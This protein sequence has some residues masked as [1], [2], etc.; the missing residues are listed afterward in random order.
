MRKTLPKHSV[1]QKTSPE[2]FRKVSLSPVYIVR[3]KSTLRSVS[4]AQAFIPENFHSFSL[5]SVIDQRV[6]IRLQPWPG[7]SEALEE[8]SYGGVGQ[9][10]QAVLEAVK[11]FFIRLKSFNIFISSVIFYFIT[12]FILLGV[13]THCRD[14]P[15]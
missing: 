15:I 8:F 14:E 11:L 10:R 7:D 6:Q 1:E 4:S 12:V 9:A 2:C 13:G 5:S 3:V